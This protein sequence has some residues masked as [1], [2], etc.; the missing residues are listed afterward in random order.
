MLPCDDPHLP[1][2]FVKSILGGPPTADPSPKSGWHLCP[3]RG[4][5]LELASHFEKIRQHLPPTDQVHGAPAPYS[6]QEFDICFHKTFATERSSDEGNDAIYYLTKKESQTRLL[7]VYGYVVFDNVAAVPVPLV[8]VQDTS[9]NSLFT[10]QGQGYITRTYSK[11]T[12]DF[13]S[14]CFQVT[15]FHI[16][17]YVFL[18]AILRGVCAVMLDGIIPTQISLSTKLKRAI[19]SA[20]LSPDHRFGFLFDTDKQATEYLKNVMKALKVKSIT[21]FTLG[22]LTSLTTAGSKNAQ[23]WQHVAAELPLAEMETLRDYAATHPNQPAPPG[24]AVAVPLYSSHQEHRHE[25]DTEINS[26]VY[27]NPRPLND[28]FSQVALHGTVTERLLGLLANT[29]QLELQLRRAIDVATHGENAI[30]Q[31][32]EA[33][34]VALQAFYQKYKCRTT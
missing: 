32:V 21:S 2:K 12:G 34:K 5:Y 27:E 8:A 22:C 19:F 4:V 13:L 20:P 15:N 3:L 25:L 26:I 10:H 18:R 30:P 6:I 33:S 28:V 14:T 17:K 11:T 31:E 9:S 29:R 24:L 7:N 23:M 1:E 16:I